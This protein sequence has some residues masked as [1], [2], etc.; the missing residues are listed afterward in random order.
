MTLKLRLIDY[1]LDYT[2]IESSDPDKILSAAYR[3]QDNLSQLCVEQWDP[4]YKQWISVT[5]ITE[6]LNTEI[7]RYRKE[8]NKINDD[9]K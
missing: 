7:K 5:E 3:Y 6:A 8:V 2:V 1:A 9:W 4:K